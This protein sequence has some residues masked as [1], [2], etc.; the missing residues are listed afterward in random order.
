MPGRDDVTTFEELQAMTPEQR[1]EHF[2]ASI[3]LDLDDLTPAQRDL[4]EEQNRRVLAREAR[5]RGKA[6]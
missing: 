3:V 6:S 5:L 4:L 1:R 2:D